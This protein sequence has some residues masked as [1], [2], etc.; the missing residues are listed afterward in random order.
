M[1]QVMWLFA[2]FVVVTAAVYSKAVISP[3]LAKWQ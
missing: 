3:L 2:A 1:D